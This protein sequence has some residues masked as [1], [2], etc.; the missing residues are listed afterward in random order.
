[1]DY[2]QR[3]KKIL[4]IIDKNE[5]DSLA[6]V[7]VRAGTIALTWWSMESPIIILNKFSLNNFFFQGPPGFPGGKGESGRSCIDESPYFSGTLV[8]RHSQSVS[9][10]SCEAGQFKLWE[11]YSLLYVE[12]NEKSHHQ[13]LGTAFYMYL[14]STTYPIV[15]HYF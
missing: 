10:P 6:R 4:C 1:M 13:D 9:T 3:K 7:Y 11:G 5:R 15:I 14:L 12:G 2:E 8:V